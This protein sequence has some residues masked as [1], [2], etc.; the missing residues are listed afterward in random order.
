MVSLSGVLEIF[1]LIPILTR[2]NCQLQNLK[3][4]C[5][6]S[7]KNDSPAAIY[8]KDRSSQYEYR[9]L[10]PIPSPSGHTTFGEEEH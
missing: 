7:W 1:K 8:Y 6:I 5:L 4:I 10:A 3:S 2:T 9:I